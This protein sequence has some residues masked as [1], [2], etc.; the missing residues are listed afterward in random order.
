MH[1]FMVAVQTSSELGVFML[2]L[3]LV[4]AYILELLWL[5]EVVVIVKGGAFDLFIHKLTAN[6][7]K[8]Q[9]HFETTH[10]SQVMNSQPFVL[11]W[12]TLVSII[13]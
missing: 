9:G 6:F 2:K 1:A 3:A 5:L 4:F 7:T 13:R 10:A 11:S 12:L 8:P